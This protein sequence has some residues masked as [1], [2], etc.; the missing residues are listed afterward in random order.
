MSL[1]GGAQGEIVHDDGAVDHDVPNDEDGSAGSSHGHGFHPLAALVLARVRQ[2]GAGQRVGPGS[3]V[4]D[5]RSGGFL[6]CLTR[7][8][9][10]LELPGDML[11]YQGG[12]RRP[13]F[14]RLV[15]GVRLRPE[16][17]SW[18]NGCSSVFR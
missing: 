10:D 18:G 8:E 2:G 17:G 5:A 11:R 1:G 3:A 16:A 13:A 6:A 15:C 14:L 7:T 12:S 4:W 9:I